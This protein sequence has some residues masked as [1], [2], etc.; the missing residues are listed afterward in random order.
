MCGILGCISNEDIVPMLLNGIKRLEY[1]GYDSWGLAVVEDKIKLIKNVGNINEEC[2]NR[3]ELKGSTGIAHTRWA[4]HG[5]VTRENAHPHTSCGEEIAIVHNG[6]IEN[7]QE[8]KRSLLAEGHKFMSQTD[9]EVIA[10]LLEKYYNKFKDI[11][12]AILATVKRI[13]GNFAFLA[14]F[15]KDS[16]MIVGARK[17]SPLVIGIG[18]NKIFLAS[19]VL[20]FIEHT[21]KVIFLDNLEVVIAKK[22]LLKIFDFKGK[23]VQKSVTQ[24]AW[25]AYD[26][27]KKEFSHY[28]LK[29]I[30][31]QTN[32]LKSSLCQ[33]QIKLNEFCNSI[34]S[35]KKLFITASGTSFHAGLLAKYLF[36]KISKVYCEA[37]LASEFNQIIEWVDKDTIILAISQSGET[38]DVLDAVKKAK[39][40]GAKILSIVNVV[41]SNLDR[42][43]H[44]TLYLNCGPEI[45]VAATKSF[46]SQLALIYFLAF[47]MINEYI[48]INKLKRLNECIDLIFKQK[49]KIV[50][51]AEKY[52]N[53]NDFY[54][55]GRSI[56]YPIALEGALKLKEL[57]Y[58]HAEGM[59]AGELK[60]GTL[61]LIDIG[62]PVVVLNPKDQTYCDTISNAL[63]MKARGAKII[64]I[65]NL[66]NDV[67]DDLILLP[68]IDE[69]FYPVIEA[70]PLQM[71]AYY[72][73][74]NRGA[75]VDKPRNLAK[76][77]TVK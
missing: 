8:I 18:K 52:K 30:Y 70:I 60:H 2:L 7:F 10:H 67:Y 17:D 66:N 39:E 20:S 49:D 1:R 63:E 46:T 50:E 35:A 36:S 19:D 22:D 73:A 77:V 5:G 45:G 13:K 48:G 23:E 68:E 34:K 3:L 16:D 71:L 42:E 75:D 37:V 76:S 29:E 59:A 4:T 72:L 43:S 14:I 64:G 28:T 47:T 44:L 12:K 51:I 56:H 41:G 32:T 58:I 31:E 15:Q 74:I 40:K 57:S 24:V 62:T 11:K 55:I 65:S 21:D 9:S 61:A 53:S 25:E 27:S 26:V 33:D 69:L 38:A 6:I 54:F